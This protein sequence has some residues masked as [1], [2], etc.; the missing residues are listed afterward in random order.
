M[1]ECRESKKKTNIMKQA[2]VE[3]GLSELTLSVLASGERS[4]LNCY[5]F[6]IEKILLI[7][8]KRILYP[9]FLLQSKY[10]L[11]FVLKSKQ[12][13]F[14]NELFYDFC[15]IGNLSPLLLLQHQPLDTWLYWQDN[16]DDLRA[17]S[18]QF[19]PSDFQILSH[20]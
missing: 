8:M 4:W 14:L 7:A 9:L 11:L 6:L 15:F 10:N 18:W 17:S 19:T 5:L 20:C 2:E 12:S 13:L 3:L 16:K 1:G